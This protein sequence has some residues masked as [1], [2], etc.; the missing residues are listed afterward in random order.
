MKK[1]VRLPIKRVAKIFIFACYFLH[2][3]VNAMPNEG[4][5]MPGIDVVQQQNRTIS[6]IV[7]DQNGDPILGA[8]I[9]EKGTINGTITDIADDRRRSVR[10]QP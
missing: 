10:R 7:V 1:T 4:I 8:N 6:G 3:P 5:D 2:F 9:V